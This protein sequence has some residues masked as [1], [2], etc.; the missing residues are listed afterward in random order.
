MPSTVK[1]AGGCPHDCPDTC[2]MIY[3]VQDNKLVSTKGNAKHP[4][5]RGGL[6]VKL[7]DYEKRHYHPDRLLHPMKRNGKKG[8]SS[9][10][11]ITWHEALTEISGRWKD[12]IRNHGPQSIA[13]YSYAGHQGL[14]HGI[15]GGDAFFNRLGA[16]VMERTMC[17]S[18][19]ATA[20]LMTYGPS[21]G[22]DPE[23]FQYSEFIL[24]WACNSVSTNL[25]HWHVIKKAQKN[26]AKVVVIDPYR[27]RTAKEAD[28][29]IAPRVGTDGALAMAMVHT[30]IEENL[31]DKD[32]VKLHTVGFD[33]LKQRA[34][35]WTAEKAAEVTG[36]NAEDI[37]DLARQYASTKSAAIR[38]GVGLERHHGGG[39]AIR[40]VCC[41]P[42]LTGAWREVGGG[43]FL[44]PFWEHPYRFDKICRPDWIPQGT[45]V[46][47]NLQIGNVLTGRSTKLPL[48]SLMC[49]NSNP[50][51]QAP[52]SL[53]VVEGLMRD[54]LFVVVADHFITDTACYAD[55]ILPATMGAEMED[56]ILS[57]G[58]NYLT[59]NTKCVDAPGEALSNREIFRRLAQYMGFDDDEFQW[60]DSECLEHFVDWGSPVCEGIDLAYLREHGFAR[61]NVGAA[62]KRAPHR[63]GNF[64][65]PSGKCEFQSSI[66][67]HGN[68]VVGTFRQM[69]EDLQG[70]EPLDDLPDFVPPRETPITNPKLT[71]HYPLNLVS[72]KS[73]GFL[74]SCYANMKHKIEKQ[75]EQSLL[76][77]SKDAECRD[78]KTGDR[79]KI[80]NQ[81]GG[82]L[83]IAHLSEDVPS[84]LVLSTLGY[85]NQ[86][87][88]GT[89]N[90]TSAQ[91]FS[92]LGHAP[93]YSDNLVEVTSKY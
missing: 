93:S 18:G 38:V 62:D 65:T 49:W 52:D 48:Y 45:Q 21:G 28:W 43:L 19:A 75:G 32:Y 7:N 55:I 31:I 37:R 81:R 42:S 4:M 57:W 50:V 16:S 34:Q 76:I 36:I 54:D 67:K 14:V 86:F 44:F 59:Y 35:T 29:H 71:E 61:L 74:N 20:W 79:V 68:F 2:A 24:I 47:N 87:D 12:I 69:Y 53:K 80:F 85:W 22:M 89:V 51:T 1:Y 92:D 13:P 27:S 25:H 82:F 64:P 40:A 26:G 66:A 8:T 58:H 33:E 73:H 60:S 72:P 15:N 3:E 56:I 10:E 39:Q 84:G 9:F 46:I 63:D 41:L 5:T 70:G 90:Y 23:S 30:L 6:C 11:K 91:E 77:S 88:D 78:I 83:A 17:G